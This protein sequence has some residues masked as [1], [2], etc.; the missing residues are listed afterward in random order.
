LGN[1]HDAVPFTLMINAKEGITSRH[2]G[3]YTRKDLEAD[4]AKALK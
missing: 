1:R 2:F 4:I 3:V